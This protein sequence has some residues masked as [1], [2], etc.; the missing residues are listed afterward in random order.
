MVMAEKFMNKA[1]KGTEDH[2][3]KTQHKSGNNSLA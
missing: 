3:K 2:V 1:L